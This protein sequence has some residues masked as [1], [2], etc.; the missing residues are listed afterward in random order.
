MNIYEYSEKQ[1]LIINMAEENDGVLDETL[2]EELNVNRDEVIEAE[3]RSIKNNLVM[4]SAIDNEVKQLQEKIKDLKIKHE[5]KSEKLANFMV[6][7]L[8]VGKTVKLP[9]GDIKFPLKGGSLELNDDI[10]IEDLPEQ[11]I[12]TKVSKTINRADLK[13]QLKTNPDLEKFCHLT[14]KYRSI[15]IK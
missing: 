4:I 1:Q 14:E 2:L 5:I 8:S 9:I 10:T 15:S 13:R 6:E 11:F 3:Y 12:D 7:E